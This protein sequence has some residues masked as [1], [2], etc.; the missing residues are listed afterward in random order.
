VNEPDFLTVD[1]VLLLHEE[2]L[3]EYGGGTGVRDTALLESAVAMAQQ[4]FDGKFVHDDHFAMAAAYAFHLAQNQPFVD[5]NKRT[6]LAAALVFLDLNGVNVADPDGQLY[7]AM[8]EVAE[9][10]LDKAGLAALLRVLAVP[11]AP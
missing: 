6:A 4:S 7:R 2:Q 3:S 9:K 10:R 11:A 1:D 5:G 8:I